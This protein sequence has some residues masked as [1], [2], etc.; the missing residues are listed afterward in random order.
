MSRWG[1]SIL[2]RSLVAAFVVYFAFVVFILTLL[3]VFNRES[4]YRELGSRAELHIYNLLAQVEYDGEVQI[5]TAFLD[6]RLQQLGSGLSAW[7]IGTDKRI[8]WQSLSFDVGVYQNSLAIKGIEDKKG[9]FVT[10]KLS[11]MSVLVTSYPVTWVTDDFGMQDLRFVVAQSTLEVEENLNGLSRKL[12]FGGAAALGALMLLQFLFMRWGLRPLESLSGELSAIEDGSQ[13][14]L[15]GDW[16][17]ELQ[18]VTHSVNMLLA[19]EQSRRD[20]IRNTLSDLAHSLKTPLAVL[21]GLDLE[22]PDAAQVLPDQVSRM[23]ELVQWHLSRAVGSSAAPMV[24]TRVST[25]VE[26]LRNTLLRVYADRDL[27][28]AVDT[29]EVKARI[30]EQDLMEL[31]GNVLDNAC[32]YGDRFVGVSVKA[33]AGGCVIQVDDDGPGISPEFRDSVLARGRRADQLSKPGQGI[34]LAVAL[35]IVLSYKGTLD[36]SLSDM[37][38]TKVLIFLP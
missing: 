30:D 23:D 34:G 13:F 3:E 11:G 9:E 35:D 7:V 29:E 14:Q 32:K 16:P 12:W 28:I 27:E 33:Q 22:A 18:P 17:I 8:L 24:K 1:K 25:V 4:A 20:R 38:G 2:A 21:K 31:L 19:S 36:I 10:S 6:P 5:P 26:R 15:S 37:G